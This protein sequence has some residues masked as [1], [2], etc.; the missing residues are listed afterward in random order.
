MHTPGPWEHWATGAGA[1][2]VE[3][4]HPNILLAEVIGP[5]PHPDISDEL[6]ANARLIAAAPDMLA[7]L[8]SAVEHCDNFVI[9]LSQ[10]KAAIAKAGV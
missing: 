1:T 4:A 10:A 2:I 6:K 7:A 5:R 9:W 8:E 3:A